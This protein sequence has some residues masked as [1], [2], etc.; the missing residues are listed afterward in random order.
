MPAVTSKE[1]RQRKLAL[2]ITR[3]YY[4]LYDAGAMKEFLDDFAK[5]S[6]FDQ[7][8]EKYDLIY[9]VT[10][11][12]MASMTVNRNFAERQWGVPSVACS[13]AESGYGPLMYDIVMELEGGLTSDR[14]SVK[15]AAK[16]VWKYYHDNRP[17]VK[18]KEFDD[19]ENPKTPQ[20]IDDAW[21]WP[22]KSKNPL[23]YAFFA[24][25]KTPVGTLIKNHEAMKPYFKKY[26]SVGITVPELNNY[27]FN[28]KYHLCQP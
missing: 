17:D 22:G 23:N 12:V 25:K 7:E 9:D 21:L 10:K 16:N 24:T 26:R 2:G 15:P 20:K 5:K 27:F 1:A 6:K 28:S 19:L 13:A 18:E 3:E 11:F 4:L 8:D 14:N